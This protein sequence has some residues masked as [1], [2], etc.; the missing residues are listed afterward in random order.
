MTDETRRKLR[1]GIET[2]VRMAS[3]EDQTDSWVDMRGGF[4]VQFFHL[5]VFKRDESVEPPPLTTAQH[6]ALSVLLGITP[7]EI[8]IDFLQDTAGVRVADRAAVERAAAEREQARCLH[9]LGLAR[10]YMPTATGDD[11]REA[12]VGNMAPNPKL[13]FRAASHHRPA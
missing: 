10:P 2:A 7:E 9:L 12:I 8:L 4:T 11:L 13:F 5:D 6:L 1:V 3:C